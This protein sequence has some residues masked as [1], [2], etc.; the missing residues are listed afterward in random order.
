MLGLPKATE[1]NGRVTKDKIYANASP[2][3]QVREIIKDQIEAI[4]WRNKL[5]DSTIGIAKG[6]KIEELQVF[7]IRLR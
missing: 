6:E 3:P 2:T 4:F 7:E 5:A 1:V